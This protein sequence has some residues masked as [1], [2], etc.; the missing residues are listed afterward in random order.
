MQYFQ[1]CVLPDTRPG[2]TIGKDGICSG[3]LV[4]EQKEILT[5]QREQ[6]FAI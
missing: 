5:G 4:H 3:C 1:K 2:I 6:D